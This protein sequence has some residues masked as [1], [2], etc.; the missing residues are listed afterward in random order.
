MPVS[1]EGIAFA[2]LSGPCHAAKHVGCVHSAGVTRAGRAHL[3]ELVET[4]GRSGH[5]GALGELEAVLPLIS[6]LSIAERP[7]TGSLQCR[8]WP[9]AMRPEGV[10]RLTKGR[11]EGRPWLEVPSPLPRVELHPG[12]SPRDLNPLPATALKWTKTSAPP[13]SGVMKPYP[14][15]SL[16]HFTV[17]VD[18]RTTRAQAPGHASAETVGSLLPDRE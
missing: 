8:R 3:S 18:T 10:W 2:R 13:P 4:R 1:A 15:S 7:R 5:G 9:R 14:F 16:N 12:P 11:S 17:P 6:T